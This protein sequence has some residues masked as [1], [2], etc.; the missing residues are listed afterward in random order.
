MF[1]YISCRIHIQFSFYDQAIKTKSLN[2][3]KASESY[4]L[5]LKI[6]VQNNEQ[7][8]RNSLSKE[9][10]IILYYIILYSYFISFGE[11]EKK[12]I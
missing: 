9:I 8:W 6:L 2:I 3:G 10:L 1:A 11:E 5:C 7:F 4:Q 12:N